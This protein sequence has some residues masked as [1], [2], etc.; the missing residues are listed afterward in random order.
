MNETVKI[1]GIAGSLRSASYN[2][3][4]LVAAQGLLEDG[5]T[6]ELF[7]LQGLPL[8]DQDKEAQPPPRL[9][10]FK[11]KIREADAILISTP[12]YNYSMPG[13]LKNAIDCASR[14][15]GD[16]AWRGKP[17][18][19][20]GASVSAFGGARAQYHLRQCFVYLD[21]LPINHPE[22]MIAHAGQAFDG[23]DRLVDEGSRALIR[24]L[25]DNLV[26]WTRQMRR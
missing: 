24:E 16:S 10:E 22:V 12:E 19:V 25:L 5:V 20:M 15:Y 4:A 1:L 21:M 11:K 8:F 2:R 9:V 26:R 3:A 17:V 13:V 23:D 18:A 6:L 14:P 7:D